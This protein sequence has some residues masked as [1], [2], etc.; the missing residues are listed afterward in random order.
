MSTTT[1]P[2]TVKEAWGF[3]YKGCRI[4]KV[5]NLFSIFGKTG[6]ASEMMQVVDNAC[7]SL[8]KSLNR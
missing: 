5:G 6:S 8:S 2:E 7:I 1:T 3:K 4:L